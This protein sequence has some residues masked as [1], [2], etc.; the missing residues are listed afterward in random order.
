MDYAEGLT[1]GND[2]ILQAIVSKIYSDVAGVGYI[3]VEAAT[4]DT[5]G[6]YNSKNITIDA[7]HVAVIDASRVQVVINE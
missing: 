2:V 5:A 4:G 1:V 7:R 6:T 3:T